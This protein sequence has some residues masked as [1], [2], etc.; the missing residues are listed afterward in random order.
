MLFDR[1]IA[2][3]EAKGQV[4]IKKA[5]LR[6]EFQ[7]TEIDSSLE[8]LVRTK[9]VFI[10]KKGTSFYCWHKKYY[11]QNLLNTDQKFSLI[12]SSINSL[13]NTVI[14]QF[15]STN[16]KLELLIEKV[17]SLDHEIRNHPEFDEIR[18]SAQEPLQKEEHPVTTRQIN[19]D[20]FKAELDNAITNKSSSIGWVELSELRKVLCSEL[21]ISQEEFY[22]SI[23][24]VISN[25][26]DKYELSSGGKE[27]IQL[28]G[29]IHGFVRCI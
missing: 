15:D 27:G 17:S 21:G 29:L 19:Y 14:N 16:A 22:Q 8:E 7:E 20:M 23:Q 2:S 11:L 5:D 28:R 26:Y 9:E 13:E 24:Q 10:E 6:R 1:L 12:Y 4:G 18:L 3:I 25:N